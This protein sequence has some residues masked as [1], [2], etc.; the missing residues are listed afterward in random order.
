[1]SPFA[2]LLL[3]IQACLVQPDSVWA[4]LTDGLVNVAAATDPA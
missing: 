2:F 1:M 4:T 3:C